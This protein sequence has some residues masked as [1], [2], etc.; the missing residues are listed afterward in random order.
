MTTEQ[1]RRAEK[2]TDGGTDRYELT[3]ILTDLLVLA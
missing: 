3:E 1:I 2:Y